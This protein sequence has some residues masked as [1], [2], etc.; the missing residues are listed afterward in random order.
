MS[1]PQPFRKFLRLLV[2]LSCAFYGWRHLQSSGALAKLPRLAWSP[3][4]QSSIAPA[5]F[6]PAIRPALQ[7]DPPDAEPSTAAKYP[8]EVAPTEVAPTEVELT[9]SNLPLRLPGPPRVLVRRDARI[10]QL[11]AKLQDFAAFETY[12]ALAE[13][14]LELGNNAQ[15]AQIFRAEAA[16]YRRKGLGDAAQILEDRA[17]QNETSVRVF[18]ARADA[19]SRFSNAPLEPARGCYLGAFIDLDDALPTRMRGDNYQM[20]RLPAEFEARVGRR[21]GSVFTYVKWGNFPRRWL[22][23]CKR[24]GVIPQIAWE[25]D[26]LNRVRDDAYLH[27]CERFL[28]ELDWPVW[29]R[30]AGE[31]NGEWTPYHGNP[32][33][34]KE[35]FRLVHRALHR[36]GARVATIWCVNAVPLGNIESYY[37]GD[38][39]CDW[40]GVNLYSAPYADND[41]TRAAFRQ[42]PLTLLDPIYKRYSARKPMAICEYAA[43]H[44]AALDL[45]MRPEFAIEKMSLL[46]G[47]LPLLYPR[48]KMISWFDSNNL[49]Q[50][51]PGRQLNNYRLTELPQIA[52]TFR[53]LTASAH[54][55]KEFPPIANSAPALREIKPGEKLRR[56]ERLWIWAT[57]A[58]ARP[59]LCLQTNGL[60]FYAGQSYGQSVVNLPSGA[61]GLTLLIYDG[62]RCVYRREIEVAGG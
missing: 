38:D 19:P 42:S 29:I 13:H 41:R 16:L 52:K 11:E 12:R 3:T 48:V 27:D 37:P 26:D 23:M 40:V 18:A 47:A 34:Y 36:G 32:A 62:A 30:F 43:S 24:E 35:K 7:R 51:E 53:D 55:L 46:Y 45:K 50:A 61:D 10:N 15:A 25:P 14:H 60:T 33:L 2:L 4:P 9:P 20:H 17:A 6:K 44:Q 54:F 56:G 59:A 57:S 31:M 1:R 58:I 8:T 39:A 21:L 49:V 28:R 5:P 22:Q